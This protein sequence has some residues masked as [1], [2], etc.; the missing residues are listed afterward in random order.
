M[1]LCY[2]QNWSSFPLGAVT[3]IPGWSLNLDE[4]QFINFAQNANWGN[5]EGISI[6]NGA[7]F[8]GLYEGTVFSGN[9]VST[10]QFALSAGSVGDILANAS[11]T[12]G[13]VVE[14]SP[15]YISIVTYPS[16]ASENAQV[17]GGTVNWSNFT[18][19][20]ET[21]AT[22]VM[23]YL[24]SELTPILDIQDSQ[25][26]TGQFWVSN[27]GFTAWIGAV[28]FSSQQ[29]L[30]PTATMTATW[31]PTSSPTPTFTVTPVTTPSSPTGFYVIR[32]NGFSFLK[33]NRVY[34]DINNNP[35][36]IAGYKV[37]RTQ[38]TNSYGFIFIGLVS[39]LDVD[40]FV[41]TC[42]V[43][44]FTSDPVTYQVVAVG[45]Q[46]SLSLPATATATRWSNIENP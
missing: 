24:N 12:D 18:V 28:S 34:V 16:G 26:R 13:Y 2:S 33:W 39:T 29:C 15:G 4:S 7:S 25:Y 40:G 5:A 21:T 31:T 23:V 35:T 17:P 9:S 27:E 10:V 45:L 44:H 8:T 46:G 37:Y 20:V 1:S 41:D 14:V 36:T 11:E 22:D 6:N 38:Q 32:E 43:D 42:F 30:A 3:T 19:S